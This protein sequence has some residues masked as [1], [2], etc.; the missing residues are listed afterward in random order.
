[1]PQTSHLQPPEAGVVTDPA[2]PGAFESLRI[3]RVAGSAL[4]V[5][6]SLHAQLAHLEWTEEKR[7]LLRL[8]IITLLGFAALL[9]LVMG[10]T[11]LLLAVAWD[12]AFRIPVALALTGTYGLA[13]GLAW[14][15]FK[16]LIR[17][18]E[19]SF[20]ATRQELSADLALLRSGR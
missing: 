1:M 8:L 11:A 10:T 19:D 6:A 9:C 20:S 3:L 15:R 7:R 18:G 17:L 16:R 12:T 5:Q 14:R 2:C 13:A 4:L